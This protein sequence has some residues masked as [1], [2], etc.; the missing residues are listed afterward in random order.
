MSPTAGVDKHSP[1]IP[2]RRTG[3]SC[4]A[5]LAE[6]NDANIHVPISYYDPTYDEA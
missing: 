1:A 2:S 4:R 5:K 6:S 3:T